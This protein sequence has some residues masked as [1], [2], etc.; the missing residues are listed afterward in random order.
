MAATVSIGS[1][2]N[3]FNGGSTFD[4]GTLQTTGAT[5]ACRM[6]SR[7]MRA[8]VRSTRA[9]D[10]TLQQAIT[11]PG[12]LTK[13]RQRKPDARRRKHL[14]RRDDDLRWHVDRHNDFAP[15]QHRRQ[16]RACLRPE[17]QPALTPAISVAPALSP[18]SPATGDVNRQQ[19][20]LR[21]DIRQWRCA[22]SRRDR[23]RRYIGGNDHGRARCSSTPMRA[24]GS[25]GGAGALTLGGFKF[26][27]WRKQRIDDVSGTDHGRPR[28]D[29]Y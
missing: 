29:A 11:G 25:L 12:G 28:L 27:R 15:G 16:C 8:A 13:I 2:N 26:D 6:R 24:I 22:G 3:M 20:L 1:A 18:G 14:Q 23:H 10:L 7:S 17:L 19:H 4:G 5:H 21:R 9:R